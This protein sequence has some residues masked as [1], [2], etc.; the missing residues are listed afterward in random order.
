MFH[1]ETQ[2]ESY[3]ETVNVDQISHD[4]A[5]IVQLWLFNTKYCPGYYVERHHHLNN[6]TITAHLIH[7]LPYVLLFSIP[8]R[9]HTTYY[10]N[11]SWY[12]NHYPNQCSVTT[13]ECI[14]CPVSTDFAL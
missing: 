12:L 7:V 8:S 6:I 10:S 5:L 13:I 14:Y 2:R 4:F 11:L 3:V 9:R 1:L